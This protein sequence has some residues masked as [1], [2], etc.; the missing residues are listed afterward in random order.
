M[1][2]PSTAP[3]TN[4]DA[5]IAASPRPMTVPEF[6]AAKARGTPLAVL[7]AYD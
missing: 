5:D 3:N 6:R 2:L 7:T 4:G 1:T